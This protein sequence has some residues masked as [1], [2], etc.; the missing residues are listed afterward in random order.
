MPASMF[1]ASLDGNRLKQDNGWGSAGT[2]PFA[3]LGPQPLGAW[4]GGEG[5]D[6]RKPRSRGPVLDGPQ[7]PPTATPHHP[8]C[9]KQSSTAIL[10]CTYQ[11]R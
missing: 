8:G 4:L 11:L 3:V 1:P 6:A 9:L 7:P 5:L 10:A 2:N